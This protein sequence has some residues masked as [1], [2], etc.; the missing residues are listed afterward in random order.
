VD[1]QDEQPDLLPAN[2]DISFSELFEPHCGQ[3]RFFS[4]LAEKINSSNMFLHFL[5][6]NS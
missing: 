6:L 2:T 1:A 5:H 3:E 4:S